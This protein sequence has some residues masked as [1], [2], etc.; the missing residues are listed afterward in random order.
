MM[1]KPVI[2]EKGTP[3][4]YQL[5]P[6][7]WSSHSIIAGLLKPF[8][9]G[10][11]ILDVGSASG[12]IGQLCQGR[13]FTL[14][15]IEPVKEWADA[16]LPYYHSVYPQDLAHTPD[17]ILEGYQVVIC[18]DVLE[19]LPDPQVQLARLVQ[20]QSP[21]TLFLISVPNIA[22]LW[23]RLNLLF[24]KFDYSDRGILDRTHLRFFTR[25]TIIDLV[26]VDRVGNNTGN[27]YAGAVEPG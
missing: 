25:R 12:T 7:P 27:F 24:G 1:T 14:I 2:I 15:G 22:N 5:K 16:S 6:D 10:T 8:P 3:E 18:A 26:R 21:G 4:V 23:V 19:H 11:R 13:G 9:P 17:E 20:L